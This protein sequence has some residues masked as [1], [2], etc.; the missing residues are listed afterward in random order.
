[1]K[2]QFSGLGIICNL[3]GSYV[4]T[5]DFDTQNSNSEHLPHL[6]LE[7]ASEMPSGTPVFDEESSVTSQAPVRSSLRLKYEAEVSSLKKRLGTLESMRME[8]GLSQRK[9]CQLLLVDPS[10]W[11]R[12]TRVGADAPPHIYR[13]LQWYLAIQEKYPALDIQFWLSN[14]TRSGDSGGWEREVSTLAR[15]VGELKS[16][17]KNER[18]RSANTI[19]L[20][21]IRLRETEAHQNE[22]RHSL[23]L[24][25]SAV[26]RVQEM[27]D[28]QMSVDRSTP[29][30]Q[31]DELRLMQENE[32]FIHSLKTW[33]R[34]RLYLSLA[35]SVLTFLL[36]ILTAYIFLKR[37]I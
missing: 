9:I 35:A 23:S 4:Q 7:T 37:S 24:I 20:L 30:P 10:A 34:A 8:L 2:Y 1:M 36:G 6:A 14:L 19:R 18:E 32:S 3:K 28:S 22:S 5:T 15:S 25:E 31:R 26:A 29:R 16:E 27:D 21:E 12:W 17:L 11:T 33:P 13:M